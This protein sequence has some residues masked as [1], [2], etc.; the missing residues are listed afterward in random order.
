M[1]HNYYNN[2]TF[3]YI[4]RGIG[5]ISLPTIIHIGLFHREI[6]DKHQILTLVFILIFLLTDFKVN[7]KKMKFSKRLLIL[8]GY[9]TLCILCSYI[10]YVIGCRK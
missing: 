9:L 7:Y 8:L 3:I 2:K 1:K 4:I 10:V 5:W 6:L